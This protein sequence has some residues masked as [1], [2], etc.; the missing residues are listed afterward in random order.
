MSNQRTYEKRTPQDQVID[1]HDHF[2][3]NT[4]SAPTLNTGYGAEIFKTVSHSST[5]TFAVTFKHTYPQLKGFHFGC[6]GTTVGLQA[7]F[8]ALDVT[9]GTA[10]LV[11]EVGATPTDPAT[12]D[13]IYLHLAVRN[14]GVNK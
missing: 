14:S 1:L 8:S 11:T 6:L 10:T 2:T 12:T 3:G 13:L 9:A 4:S 7:R 5:G